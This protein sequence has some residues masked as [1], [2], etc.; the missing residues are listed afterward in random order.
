MAELTDDDLRDACRI[1]RK[2]A[3]RVGSA[4]AWWDLIYDCE[5]LL[6]GE[7]TMMTREQIAVA[8]ER[9]LKVD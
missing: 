7:Q 9:A 8:V 3:S 4:H 5:A 6:R 1:M 2:K